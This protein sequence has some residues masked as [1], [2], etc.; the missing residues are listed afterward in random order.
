MQCWLRDTF[1][2]R[3]CALCYCR[4]TWHSV[5]FRV[6]PRWRRD[7]SISLL[8]EGA[9]PHGI[10]QPGNEPTHRVSEKLYGHITMQFIHVYL[11]TRRGIHNFKK[12]IY[13]P[14]TFAKGFNSKFKTYQGI[15]FSQRESNIVVCAYMCLTH[16]VSWE[17][18]YKKNC[19]LNC[20]YKEKCS[21]KLWKVLI[22]YY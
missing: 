6:E 13:I 15:M 16:F 19:S 3:K 9:V 17:Y 18:I 4:N 5:R 22:L 11:H 20:V 8:D 12:M 10:R 14:Y 1:N 7:V 21:V 2:R